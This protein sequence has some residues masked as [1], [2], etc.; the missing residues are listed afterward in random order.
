M[1][2]SKFIFAQLRVIL[3]RKVFARIVNK[4]EGNNYVSCFTCWN[5][6][7]SMAFR[8]PTAWDSWRDL[9]QV[10]KHICRSIIIWA[11]V[12]RFL[13]GILS[14]QTKS[15]ISKSLRNLLI[16]LMKKSGE[17]VTETILRSR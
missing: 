8:Q 14:Q 2:Q 9:L 12:Q 4:Y 17:V 15:I 10:L 5:Q 11:L 7:L 13:A 3:P 16:F 1:N 6:K